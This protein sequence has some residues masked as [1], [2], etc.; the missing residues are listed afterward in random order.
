M[1]V[2]VDSRADFTLENFRRVGL[3]GERADR[4]AGRGT[5]GGHARVVRRA[6]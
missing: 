6:S 4:T 1:T 5:D 3:G 2:I